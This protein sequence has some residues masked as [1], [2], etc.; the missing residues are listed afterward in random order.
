MP[1]LLR[2]LKGVEAQAADLSAIFRQIQHDFYYMMRRRFASEGAFE[3]HGRWTGLSD[4]YAAWKESVRPGQPIL[5]FNF[6]LMESLTS[7]GGPGSIAA[8]GPHEMIVGTGLRTKSGHGLGWLH[9]RGWKKRGGGRAPA[10][11]LI[12]EPLGEPTI[13]RWM[14][15]VRDHFARAM[16]VGRPGPGFMAHPLYNFGWVT[17]ETVMG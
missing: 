6:G 10:R 1:L 13:N 8:I 7:P 2:T 11:P 17:G 3:G 4:Q 12:P 5:A 9:Q 14:R 15:I 16:G